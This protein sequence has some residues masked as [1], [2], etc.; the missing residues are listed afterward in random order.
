M[1]ND[2]L[3][4]YKFRRPES[5]PNSVGMVPDNI[6]SFIQIDSRFRNC[7]NCTGMVP[8]MKLSDKSRYRSEDMFPISEGTVPSILL[9]N[10]ILLVN[11]YDEKTVIISLPVYPFRSLHTM[12]FTILVWLVPS[13]PC[14]D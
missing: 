1:M 7:A 12:L 11:P 10:K 8:R 4:R 6:L 5:K 13:S 2:A 14:P 3:T 9:S